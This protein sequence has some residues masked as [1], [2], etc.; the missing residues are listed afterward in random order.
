MRARERLVNAL[1]WLVALPVVLIVAWQS[2][3]D[4]ETT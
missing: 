2:C 1:L 3:R 4:G